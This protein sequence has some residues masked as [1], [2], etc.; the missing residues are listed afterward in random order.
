MGSPSKPESCVASAKQD[1]EEG[2]V[3]ARHPEV[4]VGTG[5]MGDGPALVRKDSHSRESMVF[6]NHVQV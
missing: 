5:K 6:S 2:G 4:E 3:V 1:G